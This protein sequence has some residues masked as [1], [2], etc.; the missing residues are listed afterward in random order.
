[1]YNKPSASPWTFGQVLLIVFG[2]FLF[3]DFLPM[4]GV[5]VVCCAHPGPQ[6]KGS[7]FGRG[8][9][10]G[11]EKVAW[12]WAICGRKRANY[13]LYLDADRHQRNLRTHVPTWEGGERQ[14]SLQKKAFGL[15]YGR[16]TYNI[17]KVDVFGHAI[18]K[19]GV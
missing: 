7:W 9:A 14:S 15:G 11:V 4:G 19:T 8:N 2:I 16:L 5:Q 6:Q 18:S 3:K 17:D 12:C 10:R 1:M 13:N